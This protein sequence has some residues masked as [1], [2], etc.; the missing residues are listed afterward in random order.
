MAREDKIFQLAK[1]Y[2]GRAKNCFSIAIRRVEKGL[3]HAYRSRR[4]KK[5]VARSE[6]IMQVRAASLEHELPYARLIHG[7]QLSNVGLDRRMLAQLAQTEP[8]T[9][10]AIVE[11][12]K[13]ALRR[14]VLGGVGG[15]G[16]AGP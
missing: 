9:F 8:Y 4:L 2:R 10:R 15:N 5:R 14:R 3:Q 12:A 6:W 13:G 7:L 11:E 16:P 1:G